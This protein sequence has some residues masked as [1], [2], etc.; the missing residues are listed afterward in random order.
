VIVGHRGAMAL[1]PENSAASFWMAEGAGVDEIELD[2]RVTADGVPIV[3]HDPMLERLARMPGPYTSR[4]VTELSLAQVREVPLESGQPVLTFANVLEMT[5]SVLQVEIKDPSAVAPLA[6]LLEAGTS[7]DTDRIN[8]SSFLPD[9]LFRLALQLPA[10]PRGLIVGTFPATP[11]QQEDLEDILILTG[12]STLHT[13]FQNL[14]RAHVE[15]LQAIGV[16]VRVWPLTGPEDVGHALALSAD[17]GTAD[18]P[19]QARAWLR[20]AD[21]KAATSVASNS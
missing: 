10:V 21:E 7:S 4:P 19:A 15:R 9:A 5:A 16:K 1:A 18:D 3:L 2:V 17:G 20:T 11:R 13:G 8:F 12:A 6:S 14:T